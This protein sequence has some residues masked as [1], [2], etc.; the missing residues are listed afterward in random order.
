MRLSIGSRKLLATYDWPGNVRQL[1]NH[2]K[3]LDATTESDQVCTQ[4]TSD[5]LAE[6]QAGARTTTD[7]HNLILALRIEDGFDSLM[8]SV[9][10]QV[11]QRAI[12]IA[13]TQKAAAALLKFS[14]QQNIG[15]YLGKHSRKLKNSEAAA[16]PLSTFRKSRVNSQK[17]D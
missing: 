3:R 4:T 17:T 1:E 13:G 16:I 5:L 9:E 11:V 7:I 15:Y 6:T 2:V 14:K 12:A 8:E 10:T